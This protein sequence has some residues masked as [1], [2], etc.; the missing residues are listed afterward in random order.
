[1]PATKILIVEDTPENLY[2]L[3]RVFRKEGFDI[4]T[5]IN[6]KEAIAI[7]AENLPSL[8]L[9]DM[10]L[11]ELSGYDTAKLILERTPLPIVA[12]TADAFPEDRERCLELGCVAYF[13][14]PYNYREIVETVREI[15][16]ETDRRE[17]GEDD[18]D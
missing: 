15:L 6:G 17:K 10:Q 7:V 13:S 8:I 11:P 1:M 2:V 9:L 3:Q 16:S 12:I 14:K 5:A 18:R 4:V